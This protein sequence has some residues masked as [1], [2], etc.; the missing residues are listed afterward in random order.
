MKSNIENL[1]INE[2]DNI[3]LINNEDD[4]FI[5]SYYITS[6]TTDENFVKVIKHVEKQVR[7][8]K[9]YKYFLRTLSERKDISCSIL[10]NSNQINSKIEFHHY[11][12]TLFDVCSIVTFD[13]L[14]RLKH[15]STFKL[16]SEVLSVHFKFL[17]GLVPLSKTI[18][19]L[20]HA[21]KLFVPFDLIIGK[22]ENFIDIYKESIPNKTIEKYNALL[23]K[24]NVYRKESYNVN[25]KILEV[26][27]KFIKK[28]I[29]GIRD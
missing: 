29:K 2:E 26:E 11:P 25:Q 18:H 6:F 16:I 9:E 21:D 5:L 22:F 24:D 15:V 14:K 23:E 8:S 17:I 3:I 27:P 28:E 7:S 12:F 4:S 20:T 13:L 1:K 19:E 10:C